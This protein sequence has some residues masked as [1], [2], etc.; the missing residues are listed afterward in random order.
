VCDTA[1]YEWNQVVK[2]MQEVYSPYA[3]TVQETR[4][5][6]GSYTMAVIG[7]SHTDAAQANGVLGISPLASDCSARDNVIAFTFSNDHPVV[8][9]VNNVCWTAAQETAHAF[10]L[11]HEYEYLDGTSACNDPMT[12]RNDCG[13][14]KFFRNKEARCGG[15]GDGFGPA[16]RECRCSTTQNSHQKILSVFGEGQSLI[17]PPTASIQVPNDGARVVDNWNT[18]VLAGSRR[19]VDRVELWLN[20][21]PWVTKPGAMF[22]ATG[23]LDPAQYAMV[24]PDGVPNGGI[25]VIARAFDDLG[26]EGD[27]SIS[28][29]KGPACASDA[30]C[31]EHQH[32]NTGAATDT[33]AAGGCYWDPGTVALGDSCSY[34]QACESRLCLGPAG[35]EVCTQTCTPTGSER[36]PTGFECDIASDN[37]SYCF[38]TD[39]GGCCSTATG[40]GWPS[41]VLASVVLGLVTRR[42][43]CAA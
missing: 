8:D 18:S 9:R 29:T 12:Y 36:C 28:V 5:T 4:P 32:C 38:K 33:V 37:M 23:Q 16:P 34:P 3:V 42:R 31:L 40:N 20:N 43:R 11:D 2:C 6:S 25:K 41:A 19:G 15:P 7:G 24:A 39:G 1:D 13:G 14:E 27:V 10:G 35:G 22:E 21:W 26:Y 30:N 17:P